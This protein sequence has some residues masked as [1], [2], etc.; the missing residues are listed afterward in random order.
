MG[1]YEDP[2]TTPTDPP[3]QVVPKGRNH[4]ATAVDENDDLD[5]TG[6]VHDARPTTDTPHL[7][8]KETVAVMCGGRDE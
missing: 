5:L 8:A 6:G 3:L 4:P 1:L 2:G 7:S